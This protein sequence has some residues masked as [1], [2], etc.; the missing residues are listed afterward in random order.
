[1][2]QDTATNRE[3]A[4]KKINNVRMLNRLIRELTLM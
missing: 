2:L 4:L 1:M 3:T